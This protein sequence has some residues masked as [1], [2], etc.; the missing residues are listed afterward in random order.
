MAI[1]TIDVVGPH[2]EGDAF[3]SPPATLPGVEHGDPIWSRPLGRPASLAGAAYNELV[4]YRSETVDGSPIAVSGIVALPP[5]APPPGGYP[6]VSWAHGTLG[7]ASRGAPSRDS[8][9]MARSL[10]EHHLI[11][12]SP[13]ALLDALL[14]RGWAVVMTD[15]EGLGTPGPHP[16][17]L[18]QSEAR[19][20][21]DIV[22]AARRLYPQISAQLTI[23][24]HS[25][26]G[27]A[28]LFAAHYAPT[29]TP[30]LTLRGVAALAPAS[31]VQDGLLQGAAAAVTFPGFAF[32]P[33]MLTGA[34][35]GSKA[36][37]TAAGKP[38]DPAQVLTDRALAL[39]E[40]SGDKCR[41]ELSRLD[42]WGGILGTE[43]FRGDIVKAPNEHQREFL[44]QLERT[45]P[46][47]A[48]SAPIR[49][50]H[51]QTDTRVG[52][53][54]TNRLVAEL[55]ALGNDVTYRIYPQVGEGAGLGAHFGIFETDIAE[56]TTWIAERLRER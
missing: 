8:D 33:L 53:T 19:G 3:Y 1:E 48:I 18:G 10:P 35:V 12:Q 11:N 20:V 45:N 22:R 50:A 15:Y 24:G 13:H 51:A 4:L 23:V 26:G 32:T 31:H 49:L 29:W 17:L 16:Y 40:H 41:V 38:I 44:R 25:Q 9:E 52:I 27:Q 14:A 56:M 34:I 47:L 6:V 21:L 55:G 7:L 2:P 30:E 43:Q 37:A 46:A 36:G 42:S 28:A 39:F 5:V 54:G